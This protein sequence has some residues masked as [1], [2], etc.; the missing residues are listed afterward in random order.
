MGPKP[1][2]PLGGQALIDHALGTAARASCRRAV[3]VLGHE[4]ERVHAHLRSRSVPPEVICVDN[5]EYHLGNGISLLAARPELT[6]GAF[7]I[8]MSDHIVAPAIAEL[9][10]A[11]EPV[12]G[13]AVL[14]VDRN[15]GGVFDLDDATKVVAPGGRMARIGK[16][17]ES[18]DAVDVGVFIATIGLLNALDAVRAQTGDATLSAGVQRLADDGLMHTLDIGDAF[19]QDVDTPEMLERARMW[20][21]TR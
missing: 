5:P 4:A 8:L 15:I 19:W 11:A 12:D 20:S 16:T 9:A 3:V 2:V 6:E 1:L 13:G 14:L 7:L 21:E 17:L 10:A 18:Y